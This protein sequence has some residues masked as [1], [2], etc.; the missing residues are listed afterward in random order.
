MPCVD[1]S[2]DTL[3][4]SFAVLGVTYLPTAVA[5][6]LAI[7][8]A[9]DL[10]RAF[11]TT[12]LFFRGRWR[13]ARELAARPFWQKRVFA[14]TRHAALHTQAACLQMEGRLEESLRLVRSIPLDACDRKVR[15]VAESTLAGDLV[16]LGRDPEVALAAL[17]FVRGVRDTPADM[18]LRAHAE[19]SRGQADA[20]R[21]WFEQAA[22]AKTLHVSIGLK[23]ML[24]G[25]RELDEVE[26]SF[27]RGWYLARTGRR[28]EARPLLERVVSS[29]LDTF[30]KTCAR[31]LLESA[32]AVRDGFAHL[33]R[34]GA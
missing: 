31:D 33:A 10:H 20:A 22:S 13:E 9:R 11:R 2:L 25:V 6:A 4:V 5:L 27:L 21:R 3:I 14:S 28:E 29:R 8:I 15:Y 12:H 26:R 32:E 16:L 18:L 23:I 30:F 19:L 7:V 24:V 17:D 34:A 1:R